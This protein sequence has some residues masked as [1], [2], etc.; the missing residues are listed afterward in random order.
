M[1][2]GKIKW[3]LHFS[4]GR[5]SGLTVGGTVVGLFENWDFEAGEVTL[6]PGD[7]LL[8]FTDGVV[9]AANAEGE[10][11]GTD[12]VTEIVRQNLFLTAEDIQRLLLDEV[13]EWT[14]EADQA[15]DITVVCMKVA[16]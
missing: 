7:L 3:P 10:Q 13:F 8:Y 12:R 11:F 9:E 5:V 15:D 6:C 4:E 16:G 1:E 2:S 14:G